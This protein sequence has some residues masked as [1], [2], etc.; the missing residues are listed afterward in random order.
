MERDLGTQSGWFLY[1]LIRSSL[2]YVNSFSPGL[3]AWVRWNRVAVSAPGLKANVKRNH[4]CKNST[5]RKKKKKN[6]F[7]AMG[8]QRESNDSACVLARLWSTEKEISAE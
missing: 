6:P 2:S 7:I 3:C 5:C 1:T 4:C 8:C